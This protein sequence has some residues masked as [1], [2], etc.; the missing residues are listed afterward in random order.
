MGGDEE[1]YEE[2]LF[3]KRVFFLAVRPNEMTR[4]MTT[5]AFVDQLHSIRLAYLR[6]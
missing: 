2:Q 3:N 1:W 4:G 6:E 5:L